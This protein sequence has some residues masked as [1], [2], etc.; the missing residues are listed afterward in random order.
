MLVVYRIAEERHLCE[1]LLVN[2][3]CLFA[4]ARFDNK[5]IGQFDPS[6][7]VGLLFENA[8]IDPAQ[9][10]ITPQIHKCLLVD[11]FSPFLRMI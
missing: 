4:S 5:V 7:L 3:F 1:T 9:V 11:L 8:F 6:R 2:F 10:E